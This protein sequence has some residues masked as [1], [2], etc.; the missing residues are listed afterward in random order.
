MKTP[1]PSQSQGS[2]SKLDVRGM[3]ERLKLPGIDTEKLLES[4]RKD[5]EA[6]LESNE[7]VFVTAE[8]LTRKQTELL[9]QLIKEWQASLRD[10]VQKSS[11]TEKLTQASAHTQHALSSTLACMKEMA[12]IATKSNQEVLGILDKRFREGL[13]ELRNSIKKPHT[14]GSGAPEGST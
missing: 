11:G 9:S 5:I 6:L 7:K 10:A 13:N 4:G 12:D 14:E 8:A 1:L 3:L 2:T